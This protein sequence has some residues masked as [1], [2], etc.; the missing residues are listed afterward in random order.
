MDHT[1]KEPIRKRVACALACLTALTVG[2]VQAHE[3]QLILLDSVGG[4][5]VINN[6]GAVAG[7]LTQN[8]YA[9]GVFTNGKTTQLQGLGGYFTEVNAISQAGMSAGYSM[10][11]DNSVYHATRWNNGSVTDLGTL[12]N[13]AGEVSVANGINAHGNV[14]G[15]SGYLMANLHPVLWSEGSATA[16]PTLAGGNGTGNAIAINDSN[17]IVG[18]VNVGPGHDH[19][20][21]WSGGALVD[22]G[23][24]FEGDSGARDI[25]DAGKIVGS[26]YVFT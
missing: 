17:Q 14:V 7:A 15:I 3:Y 21:L 9:A 16:L 1:W 2:A 6:A 5:V 24:A 12:T 22:L 26:A 10:L 19:A 11:P 8:G 4:D 20:V 18:S 13:Q 25:N 23:A